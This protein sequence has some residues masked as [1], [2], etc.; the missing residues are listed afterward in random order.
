M[1]DFWQLAAMLAF[2]LC[3]ASLVIGAVGIVVLLR[4]FGTRWPWEQRQER[5]NTARAPHGPHPG[6]TFT[7]YRVPED[8]VA[9]RTAQMVHW[10]WQHVG[11]EMADSTNLRNLHFVWIGGER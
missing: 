1:T 6:D 4:V 7:I 8:K 3:P 9:R 11:D 2:G 10:G 5:S